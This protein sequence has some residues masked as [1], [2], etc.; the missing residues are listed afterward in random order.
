MRGAPD[1]YLARYA[2]PEHE[3]AGRV[4]KRYD[5]ALVVPACDE[6][7]SLLEGVAPAARG[8]TLCMVVVNASLGHHRAIRQRSQQLF[9]E[10]ARRCNARSGEGFGFGSFETMDVLLVDRARRPLPRRQGVGLARKIGCDIALA[11]HRRERLAGRFIHMTDADAALAR[12]YFDAHADTRASALAYP[13]EHVPTGDA[14]IDVAHAVYEVHLR[15]WVLGL[16]WAGSPYAHHTLGSTI[17]MDVQA[18][19]AARGVPRRQAGEDFYLLNKLRKL[20]EI[21]VPDVEPI[22]IGARRSARVPFG[23]GRAIAAIDAGR[24]Q[25]SYDPRCF[26]LLRSWLEVLDG[27]ARGE[28][29]DPVA[30]A[31]QI[32]PLV[33]KVL[34][35]MGA[36]EALARL[37]ETAP[38]DRLRSRIH[39]W[40]DAFRTL[41]LVHGLRD[42]GMASLPWRDAL[43]RAPFLPPLDGDP[44]ALRRAMATLERQRLG[45][46][47]AN[48]RHSPLC[49]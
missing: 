25:Q 40:F 30:A 21:A 8:A 48:E 45:R 36:R 24:E 29:A 32:E 11:L 43:A 12:D 7:A 39:E 23:T 9:D 46:Q 42:G 5:H 19:A 16:G 44:Y 26:E 49:A 14:T 3:L 31:G 27:F 6:A 4:S 2:E 47:G 22:R 34:E 18:Y 20:G 41:K 15:Y 13:F 33:G 37:A 10:L 38:A 35:G 17:A 28:G 1:Q